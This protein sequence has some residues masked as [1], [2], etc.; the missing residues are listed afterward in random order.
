[1]YQTDDDVAGVQVGIPL[2]ICNRNQGNILTADAE[3]IAAQNESRR[4]ELELQDR[5]ATAYRGY[6]NAREQVE[7]YRA[8]ILPRAQ[9]SWDLVGRGYR[10]GQVDFLV[11]LTSQR[12]Y[13]RVNLMFVEALAELRQAETLIDGM[14]LS[15]SLQ[16]E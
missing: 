10:E 9:Q 3:L 2:P 16:M 5:L 12:T 11:L 14:L 4:I 15:D 13:T 6:A 8:Q 1:M 7:R